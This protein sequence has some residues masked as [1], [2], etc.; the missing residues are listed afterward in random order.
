MH[1]EQEL[2]AIARHVV[3]LYSRQQTGSSLVL[4]L[5]S[6]RASRSIFE[7]SRKAPP[8]ATKSLPAAPLRYMLKF[9]AS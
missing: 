5:M 3:S 4:Y 1:V 2:T 8:S 9:P 6:L 7:A